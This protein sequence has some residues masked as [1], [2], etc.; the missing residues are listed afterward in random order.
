V[1]DRVRGLLVA[2]GSVLDQRGLCFLEPLGL[3][4]A[5][6]AYG[7]L[8]GIEGLIA[9]NAADLR[10][11]IGG[12]VGLFLLVWGVGGRGS[13]LGWFADEADCLRSIAYPQIG[14]CNRAKRRGE[15]A[16]RR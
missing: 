8:S 3:A 1:Q 6:L 13:L 14:G 16:S 15:E 4:A 11:F 10:C 12:Q 7:P 9:C 5:A 2:V